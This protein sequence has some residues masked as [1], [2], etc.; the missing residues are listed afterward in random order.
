VLSALDVIVAES[1]RPNIETQ[2]VRMLLAIANGAASTGTLAQCTGITPSAVSR[3]TLDILGEGKPGKAPGLGWVRVT[4]DPCDRR[5]RI[6]QLTAKGA[7]VVARVV[8]E[9]GRHA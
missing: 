6:I 1:G 5:L 2:A 7:A 4:T 9:V 3:N 8:T